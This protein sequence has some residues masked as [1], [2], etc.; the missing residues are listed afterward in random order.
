M[1]ELMNGYIGKLLK[2]NKLILIGL[3]SERHFFKVYKEVDLL[4]FQK[5]CN[6][7][8]SEALGY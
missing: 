1:D 2:T 4:S 8:A 7:G 3:P 5:S 6:Y